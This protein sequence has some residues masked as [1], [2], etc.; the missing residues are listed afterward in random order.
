MFLV[1]LVCVFVLE[2]KFCVSEKSFRLRQV[3]YGDHFRVFDRMYLMRHLIT[4]QSIR[5]IP[6]LICLLLGLLLACPT[7]Q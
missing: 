5:R 7:S 1:C 6:V 4:E 3:I 2:V